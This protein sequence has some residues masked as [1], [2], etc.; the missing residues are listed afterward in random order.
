MAT[1]TTEALRK[2]FTGSSDQ[3]DPAAVITST[4]SQMPAPVD[5]GYTVAERQVVDTMPEL[6]SLIG[7]MNTV[8]KAVGQFGKE[9]FSAQKEEWIEQ[10][11]N[12]SYLIPGPDGKPV[13]MLELPPP[14]LDESELPEDPAERQKVI[15]AHNKA[16]EVSRGYPTLRQKAVKYYTEVLGL[17]DVSAIPSVR[18]AID[19]SV[20]NNTARL[21]SRRLQERIHELSS[22]NST[23]SVEDVAQEVIAGLVSAGDEQNFGLT[24][25]GYV[26]QALAPVLSAYRAKIASARGEAKKG[27][28]INQFRSAVEH[29]SKTIVNLMSGDT[30]PDSEAIDATI[31]RIMELSGGLKNSGFPAEASALLIDGYKSLEESLITARGNG[32]LFGTAENDASI[33]GTQKSYMRDVLMKFATNTDALVAVSELGKTGI[34]MGI[35]PARVER[36]I[37]SLPPIKNSKVGVL[38]ERDGANWMAWSTHHKFTALSSS[39]MEEYKKKNPFSSFPVDAMVEEMIQARMGDTNDNRESRG[40][41]RIELKTDKSN[42]KKVKSDTDLIRGYLRSHIASVS[43]RSSA[44]HA[45]FVEARSVIVKTSEAQ[46]DVASS[47]AVEDLLELQILAAKN[48]NVA[49]IQKAFE[50]QRTA[51][52]SMIDLVIH[53]PPLVEGGQPVPRWA[54][55]RS[56]VETIKQTLAQSVVLS[57]DLVTISNSVVK[58]GNPLGDE[59]QDAIKNAPPHISDPDKQINSFRDSAR[60]IYDELHSPEMLKEYA[61][62]DPS[63]RPGW[64]DGKRNDYQA[65]L[66]ARADEIIEYLK[67][68]T[69]SGTEA[70]EPSQKP[71]LPKTTADAE[72]ARK[73]RMREVGSRV[74]ARYFN[75]ANI[76]EGSEKYNDGTRIFWKWIIG[77]QFNNSLAAGPVLG[78]DSEKPSQTVESVDPVAVNYTN[79]ARL[80]RVPGWERMSV[81][82]AQQGHVHYDEDSGVYKFGWPS[83]LRW[84]AEESGGGRFSR[85]WD[86]FWGL[87]YAQ[88]EWDQSPYS[89]T[90]AEADELAAS[91]VELFGLKTSD[92][93]QT[94]ND[95]SLK[96]DSE[97]NV[98]LS[99]DAKQLFNQG[100]LCPS[101]VSLAWEGDDVAKLSPEDVSYLGILFRREG[102]MV[103]PEFNPTVPAENGAISR[104]WV[105]QFHS[106]IT[107]ASSIKISHNTTRRDDRLLPFST[108]LSTTKDRPSGW[109]ASDGNKIFNQEAAEHTPPKP[110]D[111]S[112]EPQGEEK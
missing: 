50:Q 86:Q 20:A 93:L 7:G 46:Y 60:A 4:P 94:N 77:S 90:I 53:D 15:N 97:G 16:W 106:N 99:G 8:T 49:E 84:D 3:P 98:Q 69:P 62:L 31:S 13:N 41:Y 58:F 30:A 2:A 102:L 70:Y 55:P 92:Y 108:E 38:N 37:R 27:V 96:R 83:S 11:K 57:P 76:P 29:E 109:G 87:D 14:E 5:T 67:G 24:Q 22:L 42:Q 43:R 56:K 100:K 64:L 39:T 105:K 18:R 80:K 82:S 54:I 19:I 111:A 78:L 61:G 1:S 47:K 103:S 45:N 66:R 81:D 34:L 101:Q 23:E 32:T 48:P 74:A 59:I 104:K 44:H 73:Q 25:N 91:A 10:I 112:Q 36:T 26:N 51:L 33:E 6:R 75:D 88:E 65:R 17:P 107:T 28:L 12:A 35:T 40:L 89:A 72:E 85:W 21:V 63:D 52:D 79:V 95:G 71:K 110:S 68:E 9:F